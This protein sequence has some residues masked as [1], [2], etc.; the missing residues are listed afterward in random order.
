MADMH[1]PE[2]R[3]ALGIL[4]GLMVTLLGAG[5]SVPAVV[6]LLDPLRHKRAPGPFQQIADKSFKS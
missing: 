2:R 4:G 1:D 3:S 5:F 6:Y